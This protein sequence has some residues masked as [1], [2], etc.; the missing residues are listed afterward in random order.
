ML[1]AHAPESLLCAKSVLEK[2]LL[3]PAHG[4]LTVGSAPRTEGPLRPGST[5]GL[6]AIGKGALLEQPS[7]LVSWEGPQEPWQ[8]IAKM[9]FSNTLTAVS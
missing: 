2:R 9:H 8:A 3:G 5:E 4:E 6:G 1:S 7:W